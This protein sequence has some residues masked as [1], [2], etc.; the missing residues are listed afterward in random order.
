M[1]DFQSQNLIFEKLSRK[2]LSDSYVGWLNDSEIN[3]FLESGNN[4]DIEKLN[5][6][7]I[8][9]ENKEILFW[10]II[11]KKNKKHIGNIKI[12]PIKNGVGVYGILIG[13]KNYWGKGAAYE[14]SRA[15]IDYC[16]NKLEL[17]K[18]IYN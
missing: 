12:D 18:I 4:Y 7:L 16:F 9:Q 13:D 2:H 15:V 11:I 3:K 6:F 8:K 14:A 5:E 1:I 10:A 17:K